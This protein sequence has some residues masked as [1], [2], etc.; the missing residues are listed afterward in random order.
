MLPP[1]PSKPVAPPIP[2]KPIPPDS[3]E[4]V[5]KDDPRFQPVIS[6]L[7]RMIPGRVEKKIKEAE[8]LYLQEA[9]VWEQKVRDFN[10]RAQIH[11]ARLNDLKRIYKE[12]KANYQRL[13]QEYDRECERIMAEHEAAI[14]LADQKHIEQRNR[15][16]ANY[17]KAVEKW[18]Q[19]RDVG[20]SRKTAPVVNFWR[21][22]PVEVSIL[23]SRSSPPF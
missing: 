14:A 3:S 2:K 11:N 5:T 21:A 4:K 9:A 12:D 17:A 18:E 7:D 22:P 1:A 15:I 10:E 23:S 20:P 19:E 16:E 13:R 8:D 6:V